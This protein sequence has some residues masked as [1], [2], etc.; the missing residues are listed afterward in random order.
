MKYNYGAERHHYSVFD[1]GRSS[2]ETSPCGIKAAYEHL[3]NNL[4]PKGGVTPRSGS[5]RGLPFDRE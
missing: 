5:E 1:V 4:V 2:L 3:E